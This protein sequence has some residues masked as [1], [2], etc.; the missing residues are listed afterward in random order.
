MTQLNR[1]KYTRISWFS[2]TTVAKLVSIQV[3]IPHAAWYIYTFNLFSL[4][5]SRTWLCKKTNL[6]LLEEYFSDEWCQRLSVRVCARA[7][8]YT[9]TYIIC[10]G[11][12]VVGC[13]YLFQKLLSLLELSRTEHR[14]KST[15]WTADWTVI[16]RSTPA[17]TSQ[18][19][20]GRVWITF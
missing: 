5:H 1:N 14:F 4:L 15:Y 13:E 16:G 19:E 6:L 17:W 20:A 12:W 9:Y 10:L 8:V 18:W 2:A 11:N 7:H 3:S